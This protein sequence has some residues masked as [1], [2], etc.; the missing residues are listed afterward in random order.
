M[1]DHYADRIENDGAFK[2]NGSPVTVDRLRHVWLHE[3]GWYLMN[4][5]TAGL[6]RF[7]LAQ[8]P[9]IRLHLPSTLKCC[10]YIISFSLNLT[11]RNL[12]IHLHLPMTHPWFT[13]IHTVLHDCADTHAVHLPVTAATLLAVDADHDRR[14]TENDL[15]D[16]AAFA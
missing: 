5:S 6:S 8:G 9:A 1:T 4:P 3:V 16:L 13:D 11:R 12:Y 15:A 2:V 7:L 10:I 14:Y